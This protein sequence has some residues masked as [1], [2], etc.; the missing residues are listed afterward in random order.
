MR[1]ADIMTTNPIT[2]APEATARSAA[3]L[4]ADQ[5]IGSVVV[6][7]GDKPVGIVTDR[8]IALRLVAAGRSQEETPVADIMTRNPVSVEP[9]TSVN[10]LVQQMCSSQVRRILVVD[11][12]GKLVGIVSSGDLAQQTDGLEISGR[13]LEAVTTP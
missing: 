2:V 11:A 6:V 13:L 3:V 9:T 5:D 8:D 1:T 4:M 10:D 12:T 7:L